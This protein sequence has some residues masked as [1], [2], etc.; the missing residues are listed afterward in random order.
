MD[1]LDRIQYGCVKF[2]D[3]RHHDTGWASIAGKP[4]FRI[5]NTRDLSS[6]V[7]W[8]TNLDYEMSFQSGMGMHAGFRR[9]D[10]LSEY[11]LRT[12]KKEATFTGE[13]YDFSKILG[14]QSI[15][16][17]EL[18]ERGAAIF[19]RVMA[20][21]S[22][23]LGI[24]DPPPYSL[25]RGIRDSM[26][27][28]DA[29]LPQVIVDA[30]EDATSSFVWV[31]RDT[32]LSNAD[33]WLTLSLPRVNH[34]T[35]CANFPEP[36]G[37]WLPL[38]LPNQNEDAIDDW[39]CDLNG[40]FIAQFSIENMNEQAHRLV[41]FGSGRK[42]RRWTTGVELAVLNKVGRVTL[43]KAYRPSSVAPIESLLPLLES[44]NDMHELSLST[45]LLWQN[46]WTGLCSKRQPPAHIRRNNPSINALAPFIRAN[47]RNACFLAA[48]ALQKKGIQI[49]SYG[50]GKI[51][52]QHNG[53]DERLAEILRKTQ[54]IPSFLS[55]KQRND[56][57]IDTPI[58]MMQEIYMQGD[59]NRLNDAD[60]QIT[61]LICKM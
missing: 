54:L 10:Y 43:K 39:A 26:M 52:I 60:Q 36:M 23:K 61:D 19:D 13:L 7:V 48:L 15:N 33:T 41:N 58:K 32:A 37:D 12:A 17:P 21:A 11:F 53:D 4:A 59:F 9:S 44:H 16:G 3:V 57:E 22:H 18:T 56:I 49:I 5:A 27:G 25:S 46:I 45:G 6:D 20:L 29:I 42:T 51:T 34:G 30:L 1:E 24:Q 35:A 28:Y 14:S 2:D 55:T 31:E 47:D 38:Q 8:L 50:R 40:Y